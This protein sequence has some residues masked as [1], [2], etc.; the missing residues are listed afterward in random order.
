MLPS[1]LI[2]SS[3][4]ESLKICVNTFSVT[5][6]HQHG[7]GSS[8]D[9][10]LEY[11]IRNRRGSPVP[12]CTGQMR[13]CRLLFEDYLHVYFGVGSPSRCPART[14]YGKI[15]PGFWVS[16]KMQLQWAWEGHVLESFSGT[17]RVFDRAGLRRLV[18]D[19]TICWLENCYYILTEF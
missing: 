19:S 9:R 10:V 4:V 17:M 12:P 6:H 2:F 11:P 14:G 8:L 3:H 13:S 7:R 1:R 5:R 15:E 18:N 16:W